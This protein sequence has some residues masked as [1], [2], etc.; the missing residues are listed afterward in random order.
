MSVKWEEKNLLYTKQLIKKW[1]NG[2]LGFHVRI[3]KGFRKLL[4]CNSIYFLVGNSAIVL[5]CILIIILEH[6]YTNKMADVVVMAM[7]NNYE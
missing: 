1:G 3:A 6:F 7:M 2:P 5:G 4:S